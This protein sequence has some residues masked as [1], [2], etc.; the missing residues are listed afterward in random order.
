MQ[1]APVG[2]WWRRDENVDQVGFSSREQACVT[3]LV[4]DFLFFL[5]FVD[6]EGEFSQ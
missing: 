6:V 5:F 4:L 2:R 3:I 1:H